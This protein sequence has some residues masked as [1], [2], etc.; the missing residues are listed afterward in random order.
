V[1]RLLLGG[2]L[3]ASPA[4]RTPG[5]PAPQ[6]TP[7][8]EAQVL[9][10]R[11]DGARAVELLERLHRDAPGD[12]TLARMLAEAHVKAGSGAAFLARLAAVDTPISHY[13]QGLVRFSNAAEAS[14]PAIEAF[15]RAATLA[16]EEPEFRYRLGVALLESERYE[17]AREALES[18]V[19]DGGRPAWSLALAKA[20]A[21]TGDARGAVES[22]RTV[23]TGDP[24]P[25]DV[26]TARALMDQLVDPFSAVPR[27]ARGQLEQAMQWLELADIPSEAID[28]L[29]EL[30][31]DYP[32]A[33]IVHALL[34]LSWARLDDA[35]R[36]V[37]ELKRAIELAPDDG[38]HHLYLA[39]LYDSRQR[40]KIA[41]EHFKKALERNPVLDRAWLKLGDA[42]LERQDLVTARRHYEIAA[43][44]LPESAPVRGKLAL[45]HQLD[46]NWPAA[47]RELRAVLQ[48]EPENLEFMLR[49]GVLHTER[50]TKSRSSSEREA[51]AREATTWLE[52]V[53][54][55]QPEN[56][57]ASRAL[58]R[59]KAK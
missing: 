47:D 34:G 30:A 18:A 26:K 15:R 7:R 51:A 55:Q 35:G 13:Q 48:W 27:A 8:E 42:A 24:T 21:R 12:L 1:K 10:Q 22:I 46:G 59:L 4:C 17:A 45:V 37:D 36:A 6:L 50:F 2:L 25:A 44:L 54:A 19:R 56:A 39:E 33:A 41:E 53:L 52:K 43:R 40:P 20:R 58:E 23:V 5:R 14:G 9:L 3:L 11:G 16:P 28:R 32:D 31:R 38:K 57:L 49:L 29:E